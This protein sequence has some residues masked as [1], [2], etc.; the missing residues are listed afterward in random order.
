MVAEDDT[1]KNSTWENTGSSFYRMIEM[2][3]FTAPRLPD[4]MAPSHLTISA[5]LKEL[6][7]PSD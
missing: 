6:F 5:S 7:L 2:G 3:D 4:F 1:A